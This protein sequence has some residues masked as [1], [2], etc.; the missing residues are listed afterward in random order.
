MPKLEHLDD[1]AVSAMRADRVAGVDLK[2][3]SQTYK[4]SIA[5]ASK[6]CCG[7]MRADAPG[8]ILKLPRRPRVDG[9]RVLGMR[10][11]PLRGRQEILLFNAILS[12][13]GKGIPFDAQAFSRE[14]SVSLESVF[15]TRRRVTRLWDRVL[16]GYR[17][18]PQ[19]ACWV[20]T[21]SLHSQTNRPRLVYSE[22]GPDS[23][24]HQ[25]SASPMQLL[26]RY[27]RPEDPAPP[28]LQPRKGCHVL[29]VSPSHAKAG[30]PR[31]GPSAASAPIPP[32][33]SSV[34]ERAA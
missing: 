28:L 34:M 24:F 4:V 16:N 12:A 13:A 17:V 22:R 20:W 26:W 14:H 33:A 25:Y 7:R 1:A 21:G 3:L 23:R 27:F 31:Q 18:D 8:A 5:S 10:P 15:L 6:I 11:T 2:T 32:P 9:N 19:T 29:C 30:S